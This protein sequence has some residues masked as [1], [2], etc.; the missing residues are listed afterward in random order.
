MEILQC[1]T[2][3]EIP[4]LMRR[5]HDVSGHDGINTTYNL[6]S[7]K[8]YWKGMSQDVKDYVSEIVCMVHIY[9]S[10]IYILCIVFIL[11]YICCETQ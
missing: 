7:S 9:T 8:Y 4:E 5:Y 11:I 3:C 6:I 1:P 2:K 10:F